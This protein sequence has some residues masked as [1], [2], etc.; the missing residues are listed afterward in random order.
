[1]ADPERKSRVGNSSG[2]VSGLKVAGSRRHRVCA[3][4]AVVVLLAMSGVLVSGVAALA[5]GRAPGETG[6]VRIATA[7]KAASPGFGA[8]PVT[9]SRPA[10][11]FRITRANVVPKRSVPDSIR[12]LRTYFRFTATRRTPVSVRFRRLGSRK[13]VRRLV[14]G[15][16][17]GARPGRWHRVDW[18]GRTR[19]GRLAPAGKYVA[20]AGPV[21]G[22]LRRVARFRLFGHTHPIA[23]PHGT[24]GP[25][26]R[27]GAGRVGGRTHQGFD[28]T[29][30]CGTPLV[31]VRPGR[32]LKVATDPALKGNYVVMKG[33]GER[34]TYLYAHM[35]RPAAVRKGQKVRAGRR[36]G[37]IGRTGN[38]RSTPCHLHIE[39][40]SRGRLLDPWPILRSW[41]W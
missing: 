22:P 3:R 25:V 38:A 30:R 34:R 6:A 36:L 9:A 21:G 18:N 28:A 1:M 4:T 27:F 39:I 23:G 11:R 31:A 2:P 12:P 32:I 16:R 20:L 24:R 5:S 19:K 33:E 10:I 26:G 7:D 40:R 41:E 37:S 29:G 14:V 17:H 8:S 15:R 35:R 13:T